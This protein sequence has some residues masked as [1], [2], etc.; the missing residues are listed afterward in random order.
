M[1]GEW[2]G[3]ASHRFRRIGEDPYSSSSNMTRNRRSMHTPERYSGIAEDIQ[4]QRA[5]V[6]TAT[7]E[8]A[9]RAGSSLPL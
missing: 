5:M 1:T 8:A 4:R 2:R 3:G 9:L 7:R 6:L